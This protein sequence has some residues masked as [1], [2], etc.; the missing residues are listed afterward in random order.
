MKVV[1][2][3]GPNRSRIR[4]H[5]GSAA[6]GCFVCLLALAAAGFDAPDPA[7]GVASVV[8]EV[9][10][11]YTLWRFFKRAVPSVRRNEFTL[12]LSNSCWR[13]TTLDPESTNWTQSRWTAACVDQAEL[14]HVHYQPDAVTIAHVESNSIPTGFL[15]RSP[16]YLWLM[17][18]SG[19]YLDRV[20]TNRLPPL[21]AEVCRTK[22]DNDLT[23]PVLLTRHEAPP[24]LPERIV[25]LN[26]G[27][28]H[29]TDRQNK[30][31]SY[32]M[33]PPFRD[34]FT[35]A[36]FEALDFTNAGRFYLPTRLSMTEFVLETKGGRQTNLTVGSH[37]EAA[38]R[39]VRT[40]LTI[41][42]FLPELWTRTV[43]IDRRQAVMHTHPQKELQYQNWGTRGWPS[44]VQSVR[45][46]ETLY[47]GLPR[48]SASRWGWA[49]ALMVLIAPL[50][51]IAFKGIWQR[52][53][54]P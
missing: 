41:K 53:A 7:P 52:K 12:S 14:F 42:G 13:I 24:R 27:C 29:V 6:F 45:D 30:P 39:V 47:R 46:S 54:G 36:I 16:G 23:L 11:N 9:E 34:G 5:Q 1:F 17:L 10:G 37:F 8:Y 48:P 15:D 22:Y 21:Y 38:V 33:N 43:F 3:K 49:M 19:Y 26:D 20:A 32:R 25:Y 35:N 2:G 4:E 28:W 40:N 44:A 18:A 50:A 31:V 51:L